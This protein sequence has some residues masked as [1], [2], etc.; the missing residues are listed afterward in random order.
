MLK[1]YR[2]R[3]VISMNFANYECQKETAIKQSSNLNKII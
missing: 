1:N 3:V 2:E